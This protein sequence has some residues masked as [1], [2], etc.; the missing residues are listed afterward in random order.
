MLLS[1]KK[2]GTRR[3]IAI[4]VPSLRIVVQTFC[5]MLLPKILWDG[6]YHTI[7]PEGSKVPHAYNILG[8]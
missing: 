1:R 5:P 8:G 3:K 6:D 7:T 2:E 4:L